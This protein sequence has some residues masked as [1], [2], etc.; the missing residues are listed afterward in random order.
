MAYLVKY[1]VTFD[2]QEIDVKGELKVDGGVAYWEEE[3][4]DYIVVKDKKTA[5]G[6]VFSI[7]NDPDKI[8][9]ALVEIPQKVWDSKDGLAETH[10]TIDS[11]EKI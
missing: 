9:D 2:P 3:S 7:F 11:V 10:L 4:D 5:E 6:Y 1:T 8:E